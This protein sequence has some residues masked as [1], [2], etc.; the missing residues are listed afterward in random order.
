M[1]RYF[2]DV[3]YENQSTVKII[4]DDFHHM[5][6]VMRM[7]VD[8]SVYVVFNN[9]ISAI[10]KLVDIEEQSVVC[11]I[12]QLEEVEKELPIDVTIASGLPKGDKLELVIQKGTELGAHQFLPFKASRSI[13]KWDNQLKE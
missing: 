2:I 13:V 6:R 1:Q 5:T 7:K 9:Q 3:A 4:G 12:E 11:A 10:A 8:D